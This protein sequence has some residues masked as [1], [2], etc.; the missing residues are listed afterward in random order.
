LSDSEAPTLSGRQRTSVLAVIARARMMVVS[1]VS[2]LNVA[3]PDLAVDTGASQT[4][5]TWIIDAYTLV[6][7]G[8]LLPA[9]ALG[10]L[11]GRKGVL[12]TGLVILGSAA[13]AAIFVSSPQT[14]IALRAVM[15]VGAAV[16]LWAVGAGLIAT[17]LVGAIAGIY[18]AARAA[19]LA[20]TTAL[21]A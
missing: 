16:P 17:V 9:G 3:L 11:F 2:G 18:P 19:C 10:D 15:G 13:T 21:S 7:V 5:V 6:F 1:A 20:P 8:L 14:L 12:L 4:D